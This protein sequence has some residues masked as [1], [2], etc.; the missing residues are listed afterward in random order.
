MQ[1]LSIDMQTRAGAAAEAFADGSFADTMVQKQQAFLQRASNSDA[2]AVADRLSFFPAVSV[3]AQKS[4]RCAILH[5]KF[6]LPSLP[7]LQVQAGCN[8]VKHGIS[9]TMWF[10]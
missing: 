7:V 1:K 8:L 5:D 4:A 3:H 2:A 9:H 6:N 10:E